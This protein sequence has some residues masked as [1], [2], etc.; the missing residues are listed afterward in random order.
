MVDDHKF[1]MQMWVML[2]MQVPNSESHILLL[3]MG[4]LSLERKLTRD[5]ERQ[6]WYE[7]RLIHL[8]LIISNCILCKL[9]FGSE[10][11][12]LWNNLQQN[13][14][15]NPKQFQWIVA[16]TMRTIESYFIYQTS[17][18]W[19]TLN[20]FHSKWLAIISDWMF[21]IVRFTLQQCLQFVAF[22]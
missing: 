6:I 15:Q 1:I 22:A 18:W 11:L 13:H 9:R 7:W 17:V 10:T 5:I 20:T 16:P 3:W 21:L 14:N 4:F 2:Y 19:L 12:S 8:T